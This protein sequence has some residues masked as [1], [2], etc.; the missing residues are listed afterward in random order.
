MKMKMRP[1]YYCDHCGKGSG[2]PAAMKKHEAACTA[3]PHRAC[4]MCREAELEQQP[5]EDLVT[6]LLCHGTDYEKGVEV[7]REAANGC[8][9]CILAAIRQSKVQRAPE[10]DEDG[11]DDGV[12]V[13]FDF[14]GEKKKFWDN[15]NNHDEYY[16]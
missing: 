15:L 11:C 6:A 3:N 7:L 1:R 5:M 13:P 12:H 10:W 2:N 4:G 14:K 9:S 16:Y 8:P